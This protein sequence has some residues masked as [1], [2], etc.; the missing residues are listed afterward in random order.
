MEEQRRAGPS[1]T[2]AKASERAPVSSYFISGIPDA[3]YT[4]APCEW[5]LH[6]ISLRLDSS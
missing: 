4:A 1:S 5:P 3:S 2:G 6:C